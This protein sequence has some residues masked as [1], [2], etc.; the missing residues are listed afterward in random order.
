MIIAASRPALAAVPETS[1]TSARMPSS[2]EPAAAAPNISFSFH[3]MGD[4]DEPVM[5]SAGGPL[6]F[7][8][9]RT[10][11]SSSAVP[12]TSLSDISMTFPIPLFEDVAVAAPQLVEMRADFRR[13]ERLVVVPSLDLI[14]SSGAD[15]IG[16]RLGLDAFG[17]H[18][19]IHRPRDGDR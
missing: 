12:A 16:L 19:H 4:T 8:S 17:R 10:R 1:A 5:G 7:S 15:E 2:A 13:G 3:P 6:A 18:R 11:S 14:A 9:S